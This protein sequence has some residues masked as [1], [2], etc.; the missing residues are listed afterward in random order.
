MT[1]RPGRYGD[2][3]CPV[4][5]R[6]TTRYVYRLP[7]ARYGGFGGHIE[8]LIGTL[9]TLVHALSGTTASNLAAGGDP[10]DQKA[11]LTLREFSSRRD[12]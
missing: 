6:W 5:C 7:A 11:F 10:A 3:G 4:I 1:A 9:M 12:N 2:I 8:R